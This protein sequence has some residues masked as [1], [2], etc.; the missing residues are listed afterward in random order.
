MFF[1]VIL[2]CSTRAHNS[3]LKLCNTNCVQPIKCNLIICLKCK[4]KFIFF[5]KVI[6]MYVKELNL[7]KVG[8]HHLLKF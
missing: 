4:A 5:N 1:G 6:F 3:R 2:N 7:G 8:Q